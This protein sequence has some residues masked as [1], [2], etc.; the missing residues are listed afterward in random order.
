MD[1]NSEEY[2][3]F[4][5]AL[6]NLKL[7]RVPALASVIRQ[8]GHESV[9]THGLNPQHDTVSCQMDGDVICGSFNAIFPILFADGTKWV[10]K[11]PASG[12]KEKFDATAAEGLR[13]EV[14]TMRLIKRETQIPIP[15][16]YAFDVSLDNVIG[17]PYILMERLPGK[18][19]YT[20]W[21]EEGVSRVKLNRFRAKALQGLADAMV[22]LNKFK[23]QEGGGL[24]FDADGE[25]A[26]I[27]SAKV[28]D[29]WTQLQKRV[30]SHDMAY[31][32]IGP[33]KQPKAS[34]LAMIERRDGECNDDD[35]F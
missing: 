19:L 9:Y 12:Y 22:Q 15:E 28:V 14:L 26:G 23:F 5:S 29:E 24:V 17:C 16:I 34:M 4:G 3:T 31:C 21:F 8:S 18:P 33:F 7:D 13:S 6:Q 25:L 35:K 20:G 1:E 10:L 27:G 30:V 32:T 11:V 2:K